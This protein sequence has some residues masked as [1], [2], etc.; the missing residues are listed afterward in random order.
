MSGICGIAYKPD[1]NV[2]LDADVIRAMTG[3]LARGANRHV[4]TVIEGSVAFGAT[5]YLG[6]HSGVARAILHTRPLVLAFYGSLYNFDELFSGQANDQSDTAAKLLNLYAGEGIR[7]L[8][9]LR[10]EFVV[11]I[12]DGQEERLYLAV[13]RFR[14]CPLLY[15]QDNEKLVFAST[16]PALRACPVLAP[17]TINP[18]AVLNVVTF[19]VVTSPQTIFSQVQKL[20]PGHL[21]VFQKGE[22]L[23]T[24]Y[25]D[26]SFL[27]RST[28][29]TVELTQLLKSHFLDAVKC[30][31]AVDEG[32]SRLGTFLSGGIDSSTVT[33]I[34]KSTS[35]SEI[36]SFSIGFGE[37]RF[38][39]MDYARIA[40][41]HFGV[42]H[43][44][45]IVS[46]QDARD[47]ISTVLDYCDEPFANASAIPT[48]Y[49]AKLAKDH[50]ID[51][52]YAG[53]GGDELFA[54]NER[55]KEQ[56][57]FDYYGQIPGWFRS[58]CMQ[59]LVNT[60]SEVTGWN[61]L[62]KG[63]K[64]IQR[65]NEPYPDR[66]WTYGFFKLMP[67]EKF[68]HS[69]LLQALGLRCDPY[70]S[71]RRHYL[72]APAKN[73]LDRQLYVDLKLAIGDND[74]IKVTRMAEAAGVTVRFPFLDH[75]LAEF[76][77]SVPAALKMKGTQLRTFFK[78]AYADLLPLAIRKKTKHGF[79]LPI[80][81][82]LRT[83]RVL[84]DM[85]Y[86]LVLSPRSIQ[87]GY[88]KKTVLED[89]IERHKTDETSFYGGMLW[90]LMMLEL[91]H[92]RHGDASSS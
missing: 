52:L 55:Y 22:A 12:W 42:V 1:S 67:V 13:D 31:S 25:W 48:F 64:Y 30:R 58:L 78:D 84:N 80:P 4:T 21:L 23:V 8:N 51:I 68:I 39:E 28:D 16:M 71:M 82:W 5:G 36:H 47:A 75:R 44:E 76:A 60:L 61:L 90:N 59:P 40:A 66:L 57:K 43:Q 83:D 49:C 6:R 10:G 9:R 74:L 56:R 77:A 7:F 85:M 19:S 86:D 37:Q 35:H 81:I 53:D 26:I 38:N 15:Y 33:G 72:Q 69:D 2:H 87:R 11:A 91:W 14:V 24:P 18:H 89:I 32:V 70:E 17:L 62:V 45:Y 73:E 54:G 65:A 27:K 20:S 50:G 92:R 79:G 41:R 34:L 29:E 3:R 63:R 46:P 88:F